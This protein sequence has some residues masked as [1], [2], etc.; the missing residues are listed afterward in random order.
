MMRR[1]SSASPMKCMIATSRT[2]TGW[3]KSNAPTTSGFFSRSWG[4][5]SPTGLGL[6][7]GF[8]SATLEIDLITPL[9]RVRSA[10]R[11]H[12]LALHLGLVAIGGGT[13]P[14]LTFYF[15]PK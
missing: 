11:Q 4:W 8:L 7:L 13:S 14:S 5:A 6:L 15:W 12:C 10:T 1:G 3:S 2:P 9:Q